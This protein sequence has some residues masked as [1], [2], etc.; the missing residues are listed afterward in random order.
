MSTP[1]K[2]DYEVTLTFRAHTFGDPVDPDLA[3]QIRN[4]MSNYSD[5]RHPFFVE[6]VQNGLKDVIEQAAYQCCQ[7]RA[8]EKYGNEMVEVGPY[9]HTSR[10]SLAA[11]KEYDALM[12]KFDTGRLC[13]ESEPKVQIERVLLCE[14]E[15]E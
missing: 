7:K 9:F 5:G 12:S 15:S 14:R 4:V 8:Y 13:L 1:V 3:T 6:M 11:R 10:A 2:R